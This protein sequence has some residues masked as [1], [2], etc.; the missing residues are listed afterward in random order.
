VQTTNTISRFGRRVFTTCLL[1]TGLVVSAGGSKPLGEYQVKSV[2]LFNFTKFVSW[3]T[4]AE[5]STNSPFVIGIVG[6][7]AFGNVLD[8]AVR[9]EAVQN[10]P[11]VIQRFRSGEAIGNCHILFI[12]RSEKDRLNQVLAQVRGR[13]TLTVADAPRAAERG[14]MINLLLVQGSVKIEINQSAV[15]SA[16][17]S[18]SSKLLNL[19]RIV[20]SETDNPTA[21]P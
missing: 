2:F 21:N 18:V 3:P 12:S 17:L 13:P 10:H 16:R 20:N 8:D 6:E 4:N 19:A 14:V 15:E 11:I 1:L 9:G 5:P 7:D